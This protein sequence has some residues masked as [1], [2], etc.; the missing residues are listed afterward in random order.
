MSLDE[1]QAALLLLERPVADFT[2]RLDYRLTGGNAGL[3]LRGHAGM[4]P[5]QADG[6]QVDIDAREGGG[7]VFDT[8]GKG[9]LVRNLPI[10]TA[11][12]WHRLV[13]SARG[14]RV[15]VHLDGAR[16]ALLESAPLTANGYLGLELA[17]GA[18]ARLEVR[19][20]DLLSP[21]I[22]PPVPNFPV[23]RCVKV[24][25]VRAP[26]EAKAAGFEYLELALQ[27]LLPLDD[28]AF[29]R[30]V[31]RLRAL[32]LPAVAGY[33]FLPADLKI[34]GPDVDTAKLEAGL[35]HGL[36]RAAKLGLT[37]VVYGNLNGGSRKAPEG[38]A[39]DKAWAQLVDFG[40]R[41]ADAADKHGITVLFEPMPARQ[42]NM[43]STVADAARLARAVNHRRFQLLVDFGYVSEGKEDLATIQQA[44]RQIRLVEMSNP[45]GR[46][47]PRSPDEADYA[48]F[49]RALV[50]GGYRGGFSVHAKPTIFAADAPRA[51]AT[52]RELAATASA[53]K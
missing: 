32:G 13:V 33:G 34:V 6:L 37:M 41:A 24:V 36:A 11:D 2:A 53:G 43:V 23:G 29:E 20:F 35:A 21:A 26:E 17:A 3:Y 4:N 27:E 7:G 8:G 10:G 50:K 28:A 52:L 25:G 30:E 38:F 16:T 14:R 44:A 39:Q 49:F 12:G 46:V 18:A 31:T 22:R 15:A 40:K 1:R 47:Y 48:P 45:D 51:I 9:W 42:T 5:G 19:H